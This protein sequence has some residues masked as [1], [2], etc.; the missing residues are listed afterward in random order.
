MSDKIFL[1]KYLKNHSDLIK[2]N[3]ELVNKIIAVKDILL[4]VHDHVYYLT[5]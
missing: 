5:Y 1:N 2:P 3:D 4:D